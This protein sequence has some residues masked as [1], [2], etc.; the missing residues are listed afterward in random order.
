[1]A[2]QIEELIDEMENF[3]EEKGKVS[4]FSPNKVTLNRD[5]LEAYIDE[6]KSTTPEEIRRYQKIINNRDAIINDARKKADAIIEQA[7]VKTDELVSEHQIMQQAY[8]QANQVVLIATKNAQEMLDKATIEAN[9]IKTGA[10]T[11]TDELLSSVQSILANSLDVARLRNQNFIDKLQDILNQVMEN[12]AELVPD[13]SGEDPANGAGGQSSSSAPA[14]DTT[15]PEAQTTGADSSKS[16]ETG[17]TSSVEV[18][19]DSFFKHD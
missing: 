18:P 11:Y 6:L 14:A 13:D 7:H 1:M 17:S 5:D 9:E 8:A 10:I 15:E 16:G 2:S 4:A 3:I 12:R 19:E